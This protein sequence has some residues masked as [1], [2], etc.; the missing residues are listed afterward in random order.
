[1]PLVI[2]F[3]AACEPKQLVVDFEDSGMDVDTDIEDVGD[4]S[5]DDSGVDTAEDTADEGEVGLEGTMT[6]VVDGASDAT[7]V[8]VTLM[9]EDFTVLGDFVG[10]ATLDGLTATVDLAGPRIDDL[11]ASPD[12]PGL[13]YGFAL[14]FAFVDEDGD[15]THDEGEFVRGIGAVWAVYL[16]NIPPEWGAYGY[17][18]GWNAIDTVDEALV[19]GDVPL[20]LI[21]EGPST[22]SIGGTVA[23]EVDDGSR[24]AVLP[25][26]AFSGFFNGDYL[27]DEALTDPWTV[28]VDG[29]PDA[30]HLTDL[31]GSGVYGTIE[32]PIAYADDGDATLEE[33]EI[34]GAA[35]V[36]DQAAAML[37]VDW[38]MDPLVAW[39]LVT[40]G[41]TPGWY[42]VSFQGDDMSM[43]DEADA[44]AL[45]IGGTCSLG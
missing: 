29:A 28:F 37:W 41:L 13:S 43:L 45:E 16:H 7:A 2:L 14:P 38:P 1:M 20:A 40:N 30:D 3:L 12:T 26:T 32:V 27:H 5:G 36:G 17:V 22:L 6:F 35:C 19:F 31:T 34:L 24:L 21:A 11:V 44:A 42:P 9:L 4:D 23:Y 18:E 15:A 39:F 33:A 25:S 10:G 8:G